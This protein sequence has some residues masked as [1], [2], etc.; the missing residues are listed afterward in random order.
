MSPDQRIEKIESLLEQLLAS[1]AYESPVPLPL[2]DAAIACHME[3]RTLRQMVDRK[4]IPAYR[5][6]QSGSWRVFPKDIR[7]YLM[8]ESN[9]SPARR[10]RILKRA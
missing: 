9:Q 10:P 5:H 4:E 6:A 8:A 7:A 2:R 1:A 3:L